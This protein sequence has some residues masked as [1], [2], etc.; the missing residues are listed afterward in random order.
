MAFRHLG[1]VGVSSGGGGLF[2]EVDWLGMDEV[3]GF[4]ARLLSSAM[5]DLLRLLGRSFHP[6][7][8]ARFPGL[9]KPAS[10]GSRTCLGSLLE[11]EG[12]GFELVCG[13]DGRILGSE[14]GQVSQGLAVVR[15]F[16]LPGVLGLVVLVAPSP[17]RSYEDHLGWG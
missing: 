10:L 5:V 6:I 8:E 3:L 17:E 13:I 14:L 1:Q 11:P 16:P 2:D 9:R 15:S 12:P 7:S 4:G